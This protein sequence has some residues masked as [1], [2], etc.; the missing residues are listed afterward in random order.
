MFGLKDAFFVRQDLI[1][2]LAESLTLTL[3]SKVMGESRILTSSYWQVILKG[4]HL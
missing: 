1:T 2:Y 4:L 3:S